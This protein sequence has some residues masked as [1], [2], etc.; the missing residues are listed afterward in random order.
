MSKQLKKDIGERLK[1]AREKLGISQKQIALDI[2]VARSTLSRIERGE[3]FP[4]ADE[5][6]A[7]MEKKG[8]SPAWLLSSRGGMFDTSIK[9][10]REVLA[11][12]I[13]NADVAELLSFMQKVPA[14]KY[15]VMGHFHKFKRDNPL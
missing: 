7:L 10:N 2:C 8:I 12:V 11:F 1:E 3:L 9:I 4:G 6:Y 13:E 14:L 5:L 15:A